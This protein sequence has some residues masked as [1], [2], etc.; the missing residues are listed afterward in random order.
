[1]A[2]ISNQADSKLKIVYN[3]GVDDN[4]K[5]ITKSKTLANVKAAAQNENL[6][7]LGVAI[8]DLQAYELSNILRYDEYELINEI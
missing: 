2:V 6:Y 7:N 1:M 8:S 3:A 5:T 4:N